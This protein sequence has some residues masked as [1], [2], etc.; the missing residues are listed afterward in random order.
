MPRIRFDTTIN[1]GHILIVVGMAV[2]VLF[3]YADLVRAIDQ[4]ELRIGNL[5]VQQKQ[6]NDLQRQI[7]ETLTKIR[8]DIAAMKAQASQQMPQR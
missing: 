2:S 7:L 1:A 6:D 4:H 5:E 8:E 3:A